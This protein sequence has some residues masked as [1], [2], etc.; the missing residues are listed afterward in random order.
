MRRSKG[1]RGR[2]RESPP[3]VL[4]VNPHQPLN[5]QRPDQKKHGI[6]WRAARRRRGAPASGRDETF[7]STSEGATRLW[8]RRSRRKRTICHICLREVLKRSTSMGS[9]PPTPA[10]NFPDFGPPRESPWPH[11]L[12]DAGFPRICRPLPSTVF[13]SLLR[14]RLMTTSPEL[15]HDD[16]SGTSEGLLGRGSVVARGL[17][18]Q[19][20]GEPGLPA[21]AKDDD[22]KAVAVLPL[23]LAQGVELSDGHRLATTIDLDDA[24][25]D[26]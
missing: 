15:G 3:A 19:L 23:H 13:G 24:V 17:G 2:R 21:V 4:P 26:L 5:G 14:W 20:E 9:S 18:R 16:D 8:S 12:R 1:G 11:G 6:P 25:A 7:W 10:P 22:R